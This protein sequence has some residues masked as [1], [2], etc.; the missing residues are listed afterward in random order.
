MTDEEKYLRLD[1]PKPIVIGSKYISEEE[2]K[3]REKDFLEFIRQME[4]NNKQN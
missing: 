3:K 2:K 1:V 4:K